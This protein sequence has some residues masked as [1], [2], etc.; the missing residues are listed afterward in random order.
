[1]RGAPL[2]HIAGARALELGAPVPRWREI[3]S[4]FQSIPRASNPESAPHGSGAGPR[5]IGDAGLESDRV[6]LAAKARRRSP[7]TLMADE[8][9]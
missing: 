6:A 1:M 7:V 2:K 5:R 3:G 4:C 9:E 8:R